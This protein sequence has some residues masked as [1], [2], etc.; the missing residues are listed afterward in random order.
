MAGCEVGNERAIAV[1]AAVD[2]GAGAA[3]VTRIVPLPR[4]AA[5]ALPDG[6]DS[7]PESVSWDVPAAS[8]VK[9][10]WSSA[11]G[12]AVETPGAPNS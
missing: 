8:A 6:S 9:E 12:S 7:E 11:T 5:I 4:V 2:E 10:A 1:L 3:A